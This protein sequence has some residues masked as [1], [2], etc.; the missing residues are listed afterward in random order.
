M[1]PVN[2]GFRGVFV[3]QPMDLPRTALAGKPFPKETRSNISLNT[4][5]TLP[6]EMRGF[7]SIENLG[8]GYVA[9]DCIASFNETI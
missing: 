3:H 1:D 2:I 5:C 8:C 7:E 4:L 6:R 9:A